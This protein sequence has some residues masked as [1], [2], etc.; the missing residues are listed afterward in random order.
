[1]E[2]RQNPVEL[3]VRHLAVYDAARRQRG[4]W[5]ERLGFSARRTPSRVLWSGPRARLL[6]YGH[7]DG[8]AGAALLIVPAPIKRAYIWDLAPEVSVVR[9]CLDAGLR[10]HLLEWTEPSDSDARLGLDDHVERVIAPALDAVL[11]ATGERQA[12]LTGHSLGGTLAAIAAALHPDRVAGLALIETPLRFGAETGALGPLVAAA[13]DTALAALGRACVPGSFLSL[14][15]MSAVPDAFLAEPWL[16]WLASAGH[17]AA[18]VHLRVRRWTS[19]ELAMP[20]ALLVDIVEALYRDDRFAGASLTIDGR[21]ASP[22]PLAEIPLLAVVQPQSRVVPPKSALGLFAN[23]PMRELRV[24]NYDG[25]V[26]VALQ[27]V[28]PLAGPASHRDLWPK[29][30]DWIGA[31]W[32][33]ARGQTL[34]V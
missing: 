30:L 29:V 13:P 12:V 15:A 1:M 4:E 14:S 26:G 2:T 18:A 28:G 5:I 10:V 16:D 22:R 34:R 20:G 25:E 17:R 11:A 31:R 24:L 32:P 3:A 9:R 23:L 21:L 27:H 19:D 7:V 33:E 8:A 6:G